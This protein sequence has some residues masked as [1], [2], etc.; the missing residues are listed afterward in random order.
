MISEIAGAS[1]EQASGVDEVNKA[2]AQMDEVTQQ[3]SAL[4]EENAA[5]AKTL[6]HQAKAMGERVSFF[7]VGDAGHEHTTAAVAPA[8]T[9]AKRPNPVKTSTA[10]LSKRLGRGRR[11]HRARAGR[12]VLAAFF[13]VWRSVWWRKIMGRFS[14][15]SFCLAACWATSLAAGTVEPPDGAVDGSAARDAP[16]ALTARVVAVGIRGA[17][18]VAPVGFFHPGGPVHDKPEMA[19]YTEFGRGLDPARVLVASTSNFGAPRAQDDSSE[20]S[21]LSLDPAGDTIVVPADFAASGKQASAAAGRVQLFAAQSAAFLNAVHTPDAASASFPSVS[22]PLGI[23]INNAFGRV[24]IANA[25]KGAHAGGTLSIADPSGEPLAGAPNKRA[26]GV[27][28]GD[29]TN[30]P[31]QLVPGAL[32]AGAVATALLGASPD[33]SKRAVFA[34]LTADGALAQAHTEFGLDG[35][36]PSG[37]IAP[38]KIQSP[39][40]ANSDQAAVTRAGMIFSWVPDRLL[41]VTEPAD[42]AI[43][44]LSLTDDEKVF[45]AAK[46]N[47]FTPPELDD[48]ID[49]APAVPE[50][51]NPGFFEQHHAGGQF[52]HLCRQPRQWNDRPYERRRH[53]RGVRRVVLKDGRDLGPGLLNGIAVSTDAQEI[54]LTVSGAVPE[55]PNAPGVL[56]E[57][58][59]FGPGRSAALDP[60]ASDM[61]KPE[62]VPDPEA[63]LIERGEELFKAEFTPAEGLGPLFNGRS[64]LECHQ[65]PT[66]G[67][68]GVNGLAVV[69]RIGSVH[70]GTFE[71]TAST[72]APVARA[73][74]IAS[75]G[76]PCDL[77]AGPPA[78][79]NLIS[80]RNAPAVYGLGLIEA[81]PDAAIRA[82]AVAR[83]SVNGR[84]N[85]VTDWRGH[86]RVGR[87]GW[88]ADIATLDQMVGEAFRNELGLT[89]PRAPADPTGYGTHCG[90]PA[91]EIDVNGMDILAVTAYIAS[92]P[93]PARPHGPEFAAGQQLFA[94]TG[95]ADCHTPALAAQGA[96]V[97]LYSDL[98]VHAMGPL[99]DDGVIE[100]QAAGGDWRTTPLWGLGTRLRFL[101]DGRARGI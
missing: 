83:G 18:A 86:E 33:G 87:Y 50:V 72:G 63:V 52:R 23:S 11:T 64:C 53:G 31:R 48:P 62:S 60:A 58:E 99:L 90:K 16:A 30:R 5:T 39:L 46:T 20:G 98:L 24:W 94:T 19:A 74:T 65:S 81:I 6:E 32:K 38:I 82:G 76:I 13:A 51:A 25:P 61:A 7:R 36:S 57:V 49:L 70:G 77:A 66:S 1:A 92:M 89:N 47:S 17:G 96:D 42:N 54:W 45:R 43:A 97:P 55:Y 79:A 26:G 10:V 28:V 84:A 69:Q 15:L 56:L 37:T 9:P 80:V 85:I 35:L 73:H 100:G 44:V 4:V 12:G 2:L 71:Q 93:P 3:N 41:F 8:A 22:N 95:C 78:A 88:K 91:Q 68:M 34:V 29:R 27:F 21:V 59:A 40:E 75:L 101:H 14:I 67:G